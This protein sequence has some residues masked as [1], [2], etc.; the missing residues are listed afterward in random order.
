M[1]TRSRVRI[2]VWVPITLA[3]CAWCLHSILTLY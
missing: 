1:T 3:A 2:A